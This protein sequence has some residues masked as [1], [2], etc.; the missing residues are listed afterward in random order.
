MMRFVGASVDVRRGVWYPLALGVSSFSYHLAREALIMSE[1]NE[2]PEEV[3]VEAGAPK[4]DEKVV[5]YL[6]KALVPVSET[7]EIKYNDAGTY[8]VRASLVKF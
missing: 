3:E 8:R 5:C 4:N 2:T 1:Q 7:V 6:S